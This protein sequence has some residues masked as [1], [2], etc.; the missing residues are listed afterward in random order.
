MEELV[1]TERMKSKPAG[2]GS[3][4]FPLAWPQ[5]EFPM[6]AMTDWVGTQQKMFAALTKMTQEAMAI[7]QKEAEAGRGIL[8][9]MM[10]VKTPEEFVACQRDLVELMS[11]NYFEQMM[12]LGEQMQSRLAKETMGFAPPAESLLSEKKAA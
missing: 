12:K 6:Q 3:G 2:A 8:V 11:S 10:S 7:A 4:L 1:M 9:R 5:T